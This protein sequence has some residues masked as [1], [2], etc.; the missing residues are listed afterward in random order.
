MSARPASNVTRPNGQFPNVQHATSNVRRPTFNVD[1]PMS[2]VQVQQPTPNVPCPTSNVQRPSP[3]SNGRTS[4]IQHECST[5][6]ARLPAAN[7]CHFSEA[8]AENVHRASHIKDK[9]EM[10]L[11]SP[12]RLLLKHVNVKKKRGFLHEQKMSR[13]HRSRDDFQRHHRRH[14][15]KTRSARETRQDRDREGGGL[16]DHRSGLLQDAHRTPTRSTEAPER[17]RS[18]AEPA[19]HRHPFHARKTPQRRKK[20]Q[21]HAWSTKFVVF[22]YI[23]SESKERWFDVRPKAVGNDLAL[24]MSSVPKALSRAAH[25]VQHWPDGTNHSRRV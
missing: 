6:D 12:R 5:Q 25:L 19:K 4:N 23:M 3:R 24:L 15:C 20:K 7:H 22:S 21:A 18:A 13:D 2:N 11:M 9:R 1:R 14:S 10:P 16:G 17:A 8:I